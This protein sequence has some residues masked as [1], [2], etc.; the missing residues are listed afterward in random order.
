VRD[1]S[2]LLALVADHLSRAARII[3]TLGAPAD[4]LEDLVQQAFSITAARLGEITPGKERSFLIGT[5]VRLAANARKDR[6]RQRP[7]T[8]E[9][10]HSVADDRPSPEELWDQRRAFET[11]DGILDQMDEELR[12]VFVL[13]EVEEVTMAEIAVILQIPAGTVA[14]RLRRARE[15]FLARVH[16]LKLVEARKGARR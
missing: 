7:V 3:R 10:L 12:T 1:D 6:A 13:F 14:S 11:L 15:D 5:A 4:E 9:E 8:D 16:R 2:R